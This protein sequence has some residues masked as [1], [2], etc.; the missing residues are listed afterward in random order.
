MADKVG[1]TKE[2][3]GAGWNPA[4][5]AAEVEDSGSSIVPMITRD[6]TTAYHE[7]GHAVVAELLGRTVLR[8]TIIPDKEC[9][10]QCV[11]EGW[12]DAPHVVADAA[13]ERYH[14]ICERHDGGEATD[15]EKT[16]AWEACERAEQAIGGV[17]RQRLEAE[18]GMMEMIMSLAGPFAQERATGAFPG[19]REGAGEDN[20]CLVN[21]AF[22][23]SGDQESTQALIDRACKRTEQL[24]EE[25]WPAVEG[26]ANAL[27]QDRELDGDQVRDILAE[28]L[29]HPPRASVRKRVQLD[30]CELYLLCCAWRYGRVDEIAPDAAD[31][32]QEEL[33]HTAREMTRIRQEVWDLER[34]EDEACASAIGCS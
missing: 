19:D 20:K 12:I 5:T 18:R 29:P 1:Q 14:D 21:F 16:E 4:G 10:G 27:L 17:D 24:V 8:V 30:A 32:I 31:G 9:E 3:D 2:Q 13:L 23:L 34:A 11:Y 15:T 6:R 33:L 25:N 22:S 28:A 7:A 26:V